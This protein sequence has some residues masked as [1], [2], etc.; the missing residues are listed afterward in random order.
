M[1]AM[2][3]KK[4]KR[5]EIPVFLMPIVMILFLVGA[6]ISFF[7]SF[8]DRVSESQE[9]WG[10]FGDFLGGVLSP[11]FAVFA[12]IAAIYAY[13]VQLDANTKATDQFRT[14]NKDDRFFRILDLHIKKIDGMQI[15]LGKDSFVR[16]MCFE[17]LLRE[18]KQAYKASLR[19]VTQNQMISSNTYNEWQL[20]VVR[21]WVRHTTESWM[22]ELDDENLTQE[23]N[24]QHKINKSDLIIN[25][26]GN[27]DGNSYIED[28]LLIE[29]V[30]WSTST[31]LAFYKTVYSDLYRI[32][33]GEIGHYFRNLERIL[34]Y[35]RKNF[36]DEPEFF[37]KLFRAQLSRHEI[38]LIYYNCL[39][40]FSDKKFVEGVVGF[41]LLKGVYME[42]IIEYEKMVSTFDQRKRELS[43][44]ISEGDFYR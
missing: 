32:Y 43:I 42:D 22:A 44:T 11:I 25:A 12:V 23:L 10:Q 13:K 39:S 21:C 27:L 4:S 7:A 34:D 36:G 16:R 41:H 15:R 26:F 8:N 5:K 24:D 37:A 3:D 28:A 35:L 33:G 40:D 19:V 29:A 18:I 1:Y 9:V 31:R 38:A 30:S 20:G 17:V 2:R 14:Q 6:L